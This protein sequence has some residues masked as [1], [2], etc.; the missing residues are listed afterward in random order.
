M[1][2]E[3]HKKRK[4][5]TFMQQRHKT[6]ETIERIYFPELDGLRFFAF[7]L[8]F[9]HHQG[10][11]VKIPY[12]SV[13]STNGWIG[14]DLFFSLSAFLFT[15]L[16]IAE[17]D[18]CKTI[19]FKKFYLRRIFRIWPIYFLFIGFSIA[20]SFFIKGSFTN[21]TVIR[22]IGLFTFS[23]NIMTAVYGYNPMPYISHLWTITYEEQF[24]IFIPIIIL[25]LVRSS[26]RIKV[27][28][29]ISV[30][31]LFNIIRLVLIINEVGH[32]A[33]WV[34]PVTHFEAIVL[35]IAIGFGAFDIL[36]KKVQPLLV[37]LIGL[38]IFVLLCFLPSLDKISYWLIASYSFVGISTS[39]VL[40]SVSNS[41]YL[42]E[43]FSRKV[44]VFLG[45]RSYG[46][47]VYHMLGIQV[48]SYMVTKIPF[49]P[50][51]PF[52]AFIYA[53]SFTV[54]VSI[55]SYKII[56]LPFLKLKRKFEVIVSRPI[57]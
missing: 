29:L 40:F 54:M 9:I 42:K 15:K 17:F 23:D 30:F 36:L 11:F 50:S 35:G 34:L 57:E 7:L 26:D 56:E 22:I 4:L 18:K 53:L 55:A 8:V 24:Y 14:V 52:A 19:D 39:M 51:H 38:I 25:F 45:K 48:A 28:S 49:L 32:P 21:D 46:L 20:L 41:N 6:D 33:I 31:V 43:I 27:I 37:G 5:K 47:Y 44:F 2:W 13:L 3:N 12:L 16:L 1:I 10:I